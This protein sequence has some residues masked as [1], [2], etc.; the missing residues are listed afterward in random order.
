MPDPKKHAITSDTDVPN[1][2]IEFFVD[3]IRLGK[4]STYFAV[5]AFA[6]LV[7]KGETRIKSD[8]LGLRRVAKE[9]LTQARRSRQNGYIT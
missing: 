4:F 5:A 9:I 6:E 2:T 8:T 1:G 3:G 7:K